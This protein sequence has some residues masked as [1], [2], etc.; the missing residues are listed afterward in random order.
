MFLKSHGFASNLSDPADK[1]TLEAF[2]RATGRDYAHCGWPVPLAD[3]VAYGQWF[4]SEL[5][6]QLDEQRVSSVAECASGFELTIGEKRVRACKVVVA[7]GVESFA[8]TPDTLADLPPE[9]TV[10]C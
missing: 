1:Y 7:I 6:L 9:L 10:V 4:Q 3:F 8:H 5:G 2:C